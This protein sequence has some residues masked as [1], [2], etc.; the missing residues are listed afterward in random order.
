[1]TYGL[2]SPWKA[3]RRFIFA[4]PLLM[5]FMVLSPGVITA[6]A[7]ERNAVVL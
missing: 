3:D 1:M 5:G 7:Q 4:V 2:S 6:F